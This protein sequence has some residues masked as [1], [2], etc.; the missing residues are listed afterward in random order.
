[1]HRFQFLLVRLKGGD[2]R[3]VGRVDGISIPT[4]TIKSSMVKRE[5]GASTKFQFLLVRLKAVVAP[6]GNTTIYQFQFLLV[7]LKA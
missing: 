1:M 6:P 7:R 2:E 3:K 5:L 4:G